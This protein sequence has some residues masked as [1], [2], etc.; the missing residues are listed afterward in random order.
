MYDQKGRNEQGATFRDNPASTLVINQQ[1]SGFKFQTCIIVF[2]GWKKWC[3]KK[4]LNA[5]KEKELDV[6]IELPM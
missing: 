3:L 6:H 4:Q 5:E 2:Q 1:L